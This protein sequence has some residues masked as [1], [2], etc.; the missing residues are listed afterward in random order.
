MKKNI[1]KLNR[2]ITIKQWNLTTD[3][4]GGSYYTQSASWA[5]WAEKVNVA[6]SQSN[7]EAVQQWEYN[8]TFKIRFNEAV[9]SNMTVDEG[10]ARWLINSI[11]VDSEGYK[12]FMYLRC[13][14]TDINIDVS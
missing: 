5:T 7:T 1:S 12:E 3:I 4:G 6:G 8:T 10:G 11:E 9:R 2:R 14:K 13:S